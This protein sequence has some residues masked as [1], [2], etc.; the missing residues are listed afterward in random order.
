MKIDCAVVAVSLL[1]LGCTHLNRVQLESKKM[2]LSDSELVGVLRSLPVGL[3]QG[4]PVHVV[5][6]KRDHEL[7]LLRISHSRIISRNDF[8]RMF[9]IDQSDI[10]VYEFEGEAADKVIFFEQDSPMW[11]VLV[12][13]YFGVIQYYKLEPMDI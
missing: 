4:I 9:H 8:R 7:I 11:M 5:I 3:N 13:D 12:I 1:L 6:E 2:A 10:F